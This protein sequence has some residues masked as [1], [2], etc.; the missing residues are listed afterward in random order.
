MNDGKKLKEVGAAPEAGAAPGEIPI[1]E[2]DC[3]RLEV[4]QL[5]KKLKEK[6]YHEALAAE[7]AFHKSFMKSYGVDE[8]YAIDLHR[9]VIIKV[10]Q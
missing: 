10:P 1:S 7:E 5:K 6:E 4:L 3:L 9:G 8:S 2:T